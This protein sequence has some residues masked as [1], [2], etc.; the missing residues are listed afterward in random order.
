M[1]GTPASAVVSGTLAAVEEHRLRAEVLTATQIRERHPG[2]LV[3]D[4]EIAVVDIQAG[5]VRPEAAVGA[6]ISRMTAL[7]GALRR[8]LAVTAVES[9]PDGVEV[10]TP[11]G[12]ETFDRV[13]VSAG[14]R[15]RDLLPWFPVTVARQVLAWFEIE[16]DA[17]AWLGPE[18]FPVYFH[19]TPELGEVY[20]FPTLDRRTV[21]LARHHGGEPA[22][23]E[24]VRRQVG[25]PDLAPLRTFAERHLVGVTRRVARAAVCMYTNTPDLDFVVDRHPA[26]DRIVIVSACSGHGFKFAPVIGE[27]AADLAT[28]GA[29]RYDISHFSLSRLAGAITS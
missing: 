14:A 2:H 18:R 13:I 10:V 6:M 21:K 4:G 8:D 16:R 5:L 12:R 11:E 23:P 20:G 17:A 28:E 7:G 24:T 22:D 27:I 19:Q 15:V 1:I 26:D 29:T 9:R 3:G 25:E